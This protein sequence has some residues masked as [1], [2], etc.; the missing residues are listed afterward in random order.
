MPNFSSLA[1]TVPMACAGTL[2][3]RCYSSAH[4]LKEKLKNNKY[5]WK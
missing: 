2:R 5:S 1:T 3:P 4:G